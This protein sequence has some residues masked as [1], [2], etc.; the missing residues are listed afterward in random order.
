MISRQRYPLLFAIGLGLVY[1]LVTHW[2]FD[3]GH[4]YQLFANTP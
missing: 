2:L 4:I 1:A 3:P